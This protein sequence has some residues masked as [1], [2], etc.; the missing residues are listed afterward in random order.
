MGRGHGSPEG[1]CQLVE[2]LLGRWSHVCEV[3]LLQLGPVSLS[4]WGPG[5]HPE[6][7]SVPPARGGAGSA[8]FGTTALDRGEA[9]ESGWAAAV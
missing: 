8:V 1:R 7:L 6:W 5:P 4:P 3:I 2:G 9:R